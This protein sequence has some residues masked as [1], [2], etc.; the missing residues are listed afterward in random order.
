M[1]T[2][3]LMVAVAALVAA[4]AGWWFSSPWW[5]LKAMRAAAAAHDEPALSAHVDYPALREDM[6][7]EVMKQVT[8]DGRGVAGLGSIGAQ[9]A[10]AIAGPMIDAVVTPRGVEAMFRA[11]SA[12]E[13][14]GRTAVISGAKLP[15]LPSAKDQPII[16]RHGLSEFTVRG[17]EA[18][19][20]SLVF[21]RDGLRWRL[22][23]IDLPPPTAPTRG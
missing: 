4:A 10:N 17:R 21:H 5:T 8:T 18:G 2:R 6:K 9:V 15:K 20:A 13:K 16:E 7:G 11:E 19:S 23:G 22:A 12:Q 14:V 1:R 3:W